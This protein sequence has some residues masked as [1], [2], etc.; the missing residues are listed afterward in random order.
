MMGYVRVSPDRKKAIFSAQTQAKGRINPHV[1]LYETPL[2]SG[3]DTRGGVIS[4]PALLLPDIS[5]L[6]AGCKGQFSPCSQADQFHPTYDYTTTEPAEYQ[7][8]ST[9][10]IAFGFRAWTETGMPGGNQALAL[11][12]RTREG[13][14]E[15]E[16][17]IRLLTFNYSDIHTADSCPLFVPG[18]NGKQ[19]IFA[20]D[21]QNGFAH[22]IAHLDIEG[23]KSKITELDELKFAPADFVG[24]PAF[25]AGASD[26]GGKSTATFVF[27]GQNYSTGTTNCAVRD[28]DAGGGGSSMH[29][30]AAPP[31]CDKQRG[32]D[33]VYM[34][35]VTID[36]SSKAKKRVISEK[37]LFNMP[38]VSKVIQYNTVQTNHKRVISYLFH[39]KCLHV[40]DGCVCI[41]I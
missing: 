26:A 31:P 10:S 40:C 18:S 1:L 15:A 5:P 9:E 39:M 24:C 17:N 16:E 21:K 41:C 37:V 13:T 29:W 3:E 11:L 23:R 22:T 7:A 2:P 25:V 4:E 34:V 12:T 36:T 30:G 20:R 8:K 6:I 35:A 33:K 28:D 27:I 19:I 32:L 14:A 38:R